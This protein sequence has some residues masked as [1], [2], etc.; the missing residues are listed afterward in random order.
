[1]GC[2]SIKSCKRMM[3]TLRL[4]MEV[5]RFC[6][7]PYTVLHTRRIVGDIWK[8][9]PCE[10][11]HRIA[12]KGPFT[13]LINTGPLFLLPG[14]IIALHVTGQTLTNEQNIEIRRYLL[15]KR[16]PEGGWGLYVTSIPVS[17]WESNGQAFRTAGRASKGMRSGRGRSR[18]HERR[19]VLLILTIQAHRSTPDCLW[20]RHELCHAQVAGYGPG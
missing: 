5:C 4:N 7:H 15:N 6:S 3:G 20:N 2:A 13:V 17:P 14:L 1:M 18:E 11:A 12:I 16:R 10:H 19:A 8:C 9:S